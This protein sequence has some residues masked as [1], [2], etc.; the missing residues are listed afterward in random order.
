[1]L[2]LVV[3]ELGGALRGVR[4][5]TQPVPLVFQIDRNE[6]ACR[7][8]EAWC[9]RERSEGVTAEDVLGCLSA[10]YQKGLLRAADAAVECLVDSIKGE[11]VA[12]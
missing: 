8:F 3:R 10:A 9:G 7:M 6:L 12:S 11:G 4:A 2:G 1:M 5:M